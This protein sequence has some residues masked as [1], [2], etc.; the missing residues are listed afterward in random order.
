[1]LR[2]GAGWDAVATHG[3]R[4]LP[5]D[6]RHHDHA[7]HCA[8]VRKL[9]K[10]GHDVANGINARLVRLHE[11]V[12]VDVSALRLDLRLLQSNAF[13]ARSPPDSDQNLLR[14]LHYRLAV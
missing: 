11:L 7:G 14:F 6:L 9:R 8:Y 10:S 5:G 12:H 13:G 3:P 4:V 1:R 2:V